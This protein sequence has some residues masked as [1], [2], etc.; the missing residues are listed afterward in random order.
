[1]WVFPLRWNF[2]ILLIISEDIFR[3]QTFTRFYITWFNCR[4]NG[5]KA[6]LLWLRLILKSFHINFAWFFPRVL[7]RKILLVIIVITLGNISSEPINSLLIGSLVRL[8]RLLLL[9]SLL[10]LLKAVAHDGVLLFLVILARS[11]PHIDREKRLLPCLRLGLDEVFLVETAR[12]RVVVR[13]E[14]N[15]IWG[16]WVNVHLVLV[17]FEIAVWGCELRDRLDV[18]WLV[19]VFLETLVWELD[20]FLRFLRL[21]QLLILLEWRLRRSGCLIV[22][23]KVSSDQLWLPLLFISIS[24]LKL[25]GSCLP[26]GWEFLLWS[27][28]TPISLWSWSFIIGVMRLNFSDV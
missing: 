21:Y 15:L 11:P 13:R 27:M 4:Y 9:I 3:N 5:E 10:L 24:Y 17:A 16:L 12:G 18:G 25:W 7:I 1:M 20:H 23:P 22:K 28:P 19:L 26:I 14:G 6:R 8:F 2:N